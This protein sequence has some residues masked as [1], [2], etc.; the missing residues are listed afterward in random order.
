MFDFKFNLRRYSMAAPGSN[1]NFVPAM[2]TFGAKQFLSKGLQS[3]ASQLNLSAFYGI[4]GARRHCIARI[5]GV[6]GCFVCVRH[7]ST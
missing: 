2:D 1:F 4:W 6:L 5:K 7:G 3:S